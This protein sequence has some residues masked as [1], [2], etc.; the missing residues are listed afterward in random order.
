MLNVGG[1]L[2]K[3]GPQVK[4]PWKNTGIQSA[5]AEGPGE[6]LYQKRRTLKKLEFVA[7]T[8]SEYCSLSYHEYTIYLLTGLPMDLKEKHPLIINYT[9]QCILVV[10]CPPILKFDAVPR[11]SSKIISR[12]F[13][14][15]NVQVGS[16]RCDADDS[17]R[18]A[19]FN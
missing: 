7:L 19:I 18:V 4:K 9:I 3:M 1:L 2:F 15:S 16:I 12:A 11:H 8:K 5:W 17:I 13:L 10:S 6:N 14:T